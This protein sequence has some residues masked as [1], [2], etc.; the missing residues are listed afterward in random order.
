ME[1]VQVEREVPLVELFPQPKGETVP[2]HETVLFLP[3]KDSCPLQERTAVVLLQEKLETTR[4][5]AGLLHTLYDQ[6]A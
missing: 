2:I 6:K 1:E 3:R 5:K 4:R